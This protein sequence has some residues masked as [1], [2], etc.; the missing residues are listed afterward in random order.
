MFYNIPLK[1][2]IQQLQMFSTIEGQQLQ[3]QRFLDEL[4]ES[5]VDYVE[6]I[7]GFVKI[8]ERNNQTGE[9]YTIEH[10]IRELVAVAVRNF[11]SDPGKIE[12]Y[13]RPD[14]GWFSN[15]ASQLK[16][17]LE[18]IESDPA[19]QRLGVEPEIKRLIKGLEK[20]GGNKKRGRGNNFTSTNPDLV[21][22]IVSTGREL[23]FHSDY[24]RRAKAKVST[25]LVHDVREKLQLVGLTI[26]L[27]TIRKYLKLHLKL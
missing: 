20:L 11:L 21:A 24:Q 13:N 9:Y 27:T 3:H 18:I 12:E 7:P 8:T 10:S 22:K 19:L 26:S 16:R 4:D 2:F 6:Q 15:Q 14:I 23:L 5:R 1:K 25:Q 17:T